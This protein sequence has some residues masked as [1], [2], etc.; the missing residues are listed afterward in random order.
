MQNM[1]L[2]TQKQML[3]DSGGMFCLSCLMEVEMDY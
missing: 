2:A 1:Q 3:W